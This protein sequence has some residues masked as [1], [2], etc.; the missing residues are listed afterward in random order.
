MGRMRPTV[1]ILLATAFLLDFP[2][3]R[4][5]LPDRQLYFW[6][7]I[8]RSISLKL[9]TILNALLLGHLC[10]LTK[11]PVLQSDGTHLII[12]DHQTALSPT[13]ASRFLLPS[14]YKQ[15]FLSF[16]GPR[17][18]QGRLRLEQISISPALGISFRG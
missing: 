4:K 12:L 11:N 3:K 10:T 8:N 17:H 5:H 15:L 14:H 18:L 6:K 1:A 9:S 2:S 7:N 13:P 16:F